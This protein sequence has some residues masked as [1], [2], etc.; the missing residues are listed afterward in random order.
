M[1]RLC[2]IAGVST[3]VCGMCVLPKEPGKSK[4]KQNNS[5]FTHSLLG[6]DVAECSLESLPMTMPEHPKADVL[7]CRPWRVTSGL[8]W[9]T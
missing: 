6:A 2:D 8:H 5:L 9:L 4:L 3:A 1:R 7:E